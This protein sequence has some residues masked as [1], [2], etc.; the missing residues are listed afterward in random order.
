MPLISPE[1]L[2]ALHESDDCVVVDC[3]FTLGD[4]SAGRT[5]WA[6]GHIPG[7]RYAHLDEDLA[8]PVGERGGRH[9]LPDP[10]TFARRV[11]DWGIAEGH[12]VVAYD[13]AGGAIAGRLWW[14]MRCFGHARVAVLDGGYS[15]WRA[16]GLPV[17]TRAPSVEAAAA[18]E[19][20]AAQMAVV[21]ADELDAAIRD[22]SRL[23]I[24]VRDARRFAGEVEPLDRVAGH[25]P[26]AVNLPLTGNLDAAGRFLDAEALRARFKA[27]VGQ[28]QATEL[29]VMC[30]SGV[31]ACQTLVALEHAG[32]TGAAL[33]VGSWS[34][35]I[36]DPARP[37][38]SL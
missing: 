38:A 17:E 32:L 37:V 29:V 2:Q 21:D 13:D 35:W 36:S 8:G 9:P 14:L 31:S 3:R 27:V 10:A 1:E 16:A 20:G 6:A 11:A 7:A 34:D 23:L 22:G 4:P 5:A 26:G 28:R 12:L 18:R 24:D 30:G 15:A 19:P 33:Y 25:V